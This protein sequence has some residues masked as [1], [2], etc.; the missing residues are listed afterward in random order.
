MT[1]ESPL[2]NLSVDLPACPAT[3][4]KL[5]SLMARDDCTT[6]QLAQVIENDMALSSAVVRTVNSAL[7]GLLKRVETVHE[8]ILYLGMAQVSG[9]TYEIG[10][11]GAFPPGPML[12]AIW[13]RARLRGLA[14][15]NIAR[16]LGEEPW[17]SHTVGLFAESGRS[18]LIA[19]D[20]ARYEAIALQGMA[21][22][23]LIQAEIKAFGV[24]HTA[25][26]AALC[27]TWGLSREVAD[28]VRCRPTPP[29]NWARE[30]PQVQR[31]L[32]IGAAVDAM[33]VSP[34]EAKDMDATWQT[35]AQLASPIGLDFERFK[36]ITQSVC[37]RLQE[38]ALA[39]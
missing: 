17:L 20:H 39:E 30:R 6:E 33:L 24:S 3:L 34:I 38:A 23:D 25:L 18:V 36:Q 9:L 35:L 2:R 19:Y 10:L 31:L 32:I 27:Q 12:Q 21:D 7:F 11:R 5:S 14:M 29:S 8:G 15:S 37:L 13:D 22:A 28:A 1:I 16:Q 4:V 26:G